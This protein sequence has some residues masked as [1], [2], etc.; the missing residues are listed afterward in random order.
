MT[1]RILC[2]DPRLGNPF[3]SF[4]LC[5]ERTKSMPVFC[6]CLS[7][8]SLCKAIFRWEKINFSEY[9]SN[10]YTVLIQLI[11]I[12]M[13][14]HACGEMESRVS[15]VYTISP[16]SVNFSCTFTEVVK[17]KE[18]KRWEMAR[19]TEST[20]YPAIYNRI[21]HNYLIFNTVICPLVK[22]DLLNSFFSW[23][24]IQEEIFRNG[25]FL[26]YRK[27]AITSPH[28]MERILFLQRDSFLHFLFSS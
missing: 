15:W 23:W 21:D 14:L 2:S 4:T 12:Y 22:Y 19:I 18:S 16:G 20:I 17:I 6:V 3:L 1:N 27:E 7:M 26:V 5:I 8:C 10:N 28:T 13:D 25:S 11:G 9:P 24:W